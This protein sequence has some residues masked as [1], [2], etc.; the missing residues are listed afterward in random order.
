MTATFSYEKNVLGYAAYLNHSEWIGDV[1]R[2]SA[3]QLPAPECQGCGLWH[4]YTRTMHSAGLPQYS[5]HG[6][7]TRHEATRSLH[8]K[9][10]EWSTAAGTSR[11][12]VRP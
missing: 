5:L 3:A 11:M 10:Q 1:Y 12:T 9:R 7:P 8:A 6:A 4:G 2:C